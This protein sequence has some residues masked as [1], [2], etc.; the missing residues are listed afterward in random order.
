MIDKWDYF[1]EGITQY[2]EIKPTVIRQ[3]YE[4]SRPMEKEN[5][6]LHRRSGKTGQFRTQFKEAT[7]ISL[8]AT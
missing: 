6:M 7:I 1:V 2:V 5:K 3:I 4:K 8:N